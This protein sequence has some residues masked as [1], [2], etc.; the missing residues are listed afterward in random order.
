MFNVHPFI[1][2]Y[3]QVL[4]AKEFLESLREALEGAAAE[5]QGL[6][7]TLVMKEHRLAAS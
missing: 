7:K 1:L 6:T 5:K 4:M 3:F 2:V